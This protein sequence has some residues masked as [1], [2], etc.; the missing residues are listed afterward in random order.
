M[1]KYI[2]LIQG[3]KE[4]LKEEVLIEKFEITQ[5]EIDDCREQ[6]ESDEQVIDYIIEEYNNSW[7]QRWCHVQ[8]FTIGQYRIINPTFE[9]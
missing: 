8:L 1:H 5:E 2:A 9:W 7:E 6:G 4:Y 3:P